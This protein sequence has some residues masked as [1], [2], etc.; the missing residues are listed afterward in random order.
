MQRYLHKADRL[1]SLYPPDLGL[2]TRSVWIP[3]TMPGSCSDEGRTGGKAE[4]TYCTARNKLLQS[5][6]TNV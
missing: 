2:D 5:R 6:A 3:P 4:L 1:V